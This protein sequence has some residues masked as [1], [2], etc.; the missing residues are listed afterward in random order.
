[1][2]HVITPDGTRIAFE[3]TGDPSGKP[4]LLIN[5]L[6]A[7]L[8]G[9]RP[10]LRRKLAKLGYAVY[11]IDNRDIGGSQVFPETDYT[12]TDMA[13]DCIGFLE[14]L[15]IEAAHIV[16]QSMG[17]MIAQE[18]AIESPGKVASLSL[19]YTSPEHGTFSIGSDI[20]KKR[21]SIPTPTTREQAVAQQLVNEQGCASEAYKQD[22]EF[23]AEVG[24]LMFDRGLSADG[25]RRQREAMA[26]SRSRTALLESIK[27]PTLVVHGKSDKLLDW[28]GS[29]EISERILDSDLVLFSGLGHE[30]HSDVE[31]LFVHLIDRTASKVVQP[32][33]AVAV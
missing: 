4:L 13:F 27:A 2:T 6:G 33:V 15:G 24:G 25:I 7:Q 9:W 31:D 12:I 19:L 16:G 18:I 23:I 10:S 21:D 3:L 30:I 20:R 28:H 29:V 11:A 8:V 1:M 5:G 32:Q 26:R 22:K 17:G 14:A